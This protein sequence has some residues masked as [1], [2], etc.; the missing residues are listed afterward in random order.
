MKSSMGVEL[1]WTSGQKI[2][3][4]SDVLVLASLPG[5]FD[6]KMDGARHR[7]ASFD[8]TPEP[9]NKELIFLHKSQCSDGFCPQSKV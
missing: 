9:N 1:D 5:R 8:W 2:E 3:T 6:A 7:S 4:S